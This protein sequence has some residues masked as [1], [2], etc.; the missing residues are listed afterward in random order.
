[1]NNQLRKT[2]NIPPPQLE[3]EDKRAFHVFLIEASVFVILLTVL[4][5][6]LAYTYKQGFLGYYGIDRLMLHNIGYYYINISFK[7]IF[8]YVGVLGGFYMLLPFIPY[9]FKSNGI[10]DPTKMDT[11]LKIAK[12]VLFFLVLP[13][14]A[15]MMLF[16]REEF[17]LSCFLL[18]AIFC[19]TFL[20]VDKQRI[21]YS[22][23]NAFV[24]S[25]ISTF[26]KNKLVTF[27]A[28]IIYVSILPCFFAFM[29]K[30]DAASKSRYLVV[31]SKTMPLVIIAQTPDKL[32]VA[33]VDIKKGLIS[34]TYMIIESKS[35]VNK[36]LNFIDGLTVKKVEN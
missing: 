18:V 4:T 14:I 7:Q 20:I 6:F 36:P 10:K 8:K 3:N 26:K 13:I 1:M 32:L 19:L 27:V 33:P 2:N 34:P 5:Y 29:G 12:G 21:Y 35:T 23:C 30:I 31:E 11:S 16:E 15:I 25:L 22:A 9:V 24:N 17:I 28:I